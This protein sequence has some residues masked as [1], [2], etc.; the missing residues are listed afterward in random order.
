ML[1]R[2]VKSKNK[3]SIQYYVLPERPDYLVPL[4]CHRVETVH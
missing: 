1:T 4:E 3:S 2:K